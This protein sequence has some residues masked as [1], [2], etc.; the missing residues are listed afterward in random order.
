MATTR[1]GFTLIELLAVLAIVGV[2]L[3]LLLPAVQRVREAANRLSCQ[4]NLRQLGIALHNYHGARGCFPPGVIT[5]TT[6][7]DSAASGFTFLLPYLEQDNT[8]RIYDFDVPWFQPANYQAVGI[9]VKLFFCPSNRTEGELD[10][11]PIAA[12]W[13]M[14]LPPFAGC[15]DY[16]F[17]KGAN[18]SLTTQWQRVPVEVRGVFGVRHGDEVAAGVRMTQIT[19]GTS[20]TFAMGDAAGGSVRFL[21]RDLNNPSQPA[22]QTFTG[23]SIRIEQSWGA[24]GIADLSHPW[25]GSVF[26][27]T[28]QCGLAPNPGDEPMNRPLVTPT[29]AGG[30]MLGDNRSGRDAVSGFRSVHIGG[31]NFLFCDG[32]VRFVRESISPAVYRALSTYAGEE[33]DTSDY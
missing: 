9:Q 1:R 3:A 12:Q 30:D 18:G 32:G 26:A 29:Y 17:C 13:N 24:A 21:V 19:D 28:A 2:L 16:A 14:R 8:Y 4:N 27:V 10:L 33:V 31:C 22:T 25:Y 11:T 6:I 5:D 7:Y 15:C 23:Q 20:N